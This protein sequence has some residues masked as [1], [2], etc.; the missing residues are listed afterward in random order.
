MVG[1]MSKHF[2]LIGEAVMNSVKN[3]GVEEGLGDLAVFGIV[4]LEFK[5]VIKYI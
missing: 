4:Y 2:L 5:R 3:Q 1:L